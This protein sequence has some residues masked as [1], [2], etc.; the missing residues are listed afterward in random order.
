MRADIDVGELL[1]PILEVLWE[2]VAGPACL[3]L[4]GG[5]VIMIIVYLTRRRKK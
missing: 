1:Q 2:K 3:I 4:L 5:I